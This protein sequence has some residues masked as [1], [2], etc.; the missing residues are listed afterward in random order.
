MNLNELG[1]KCVGWI[2]TDVAQDRQNCWPLGKKKNVKL[3]V[4][5]FV[6]SLCGLAKEPLASQKGLC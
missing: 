5:E 4:S 2:D 6:E 1:R 3:R